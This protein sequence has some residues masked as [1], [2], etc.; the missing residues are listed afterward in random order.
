MTSL[1]VRFLALHL[2]A[3]LSKEVF[4]APSMFCVVQKNPTKNMIP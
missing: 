2:V 1:A 3:L 4:Q